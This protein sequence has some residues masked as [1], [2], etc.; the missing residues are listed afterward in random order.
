[1]QLMKLLEIFVKNRAFI[2]RKTQ[3]LPDIVPL[4]TSEFKKPLGPGYKAGKD[5]DNCK[6]AY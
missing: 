5:F 4:T 1:M 6:I 2:E 3:G